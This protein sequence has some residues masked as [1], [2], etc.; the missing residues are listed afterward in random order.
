MQAI[1]SF[2]SGG[3]STGALL[4]VLDSIQGYLIAFDTV[5]NVLLENG[6]AIWGAIWLLGGGVAG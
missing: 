3:I 1:T 5:A 2:I 4:A 6:R